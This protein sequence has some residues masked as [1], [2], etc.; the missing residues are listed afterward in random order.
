VNLVPL[1]TQIE[2]RWVDLTRLPEGAQVPL[3]LHQHFR[4]DEAGDPIT[5]WR[6]LDEMRQGARRVARERLWDRTTKLPELREAVY[7]TLDRMRPG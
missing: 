4:K 3:Y 7:E 2:R 1:E 5:V 6:L